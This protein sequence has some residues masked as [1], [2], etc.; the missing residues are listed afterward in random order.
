MPVRCT[1]SSTAPDLDADVPDVTLA[2]TP[3]RRIARFNALADLR[4]MIGVGAFV[5]AR[6]PYHPLHRRPDVRPGKVASEIALRLY[7]TVGFV[8]L[9]GLAILAADL[10]RRHG[11]RL[12]G[13]RW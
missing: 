4:R 3:L 7:L 5:Y 1:T 10:D 2:I 11:R 12:R 13:K 8:A 6:E 9:F